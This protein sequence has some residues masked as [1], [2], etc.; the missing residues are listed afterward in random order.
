MIVKNSLSMSV[1]SYMLFQ[2]QRY[3]MKAEQT[4]INPSAIQTGAGNTSVAASG[5]LQNQ[6][7]QKPI[8]LKQTPPTPDRGSKLDIKT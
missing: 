8:L 2:K 3:G 5:T 1:L 7:A 4:V 6:S